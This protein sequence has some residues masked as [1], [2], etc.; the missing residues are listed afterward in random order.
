MSSSADEDKLVPR[1]WRSDSWDA[2]S[3]GTLYK[4][5]RDYLEAHEG[6]CTRSQLLSAIEHDP[7]AMRRLRGAQSFDRLL[8]N[9]KYS[10]FIA[11]E[12][13]RIVRT[14]RRYGQRRA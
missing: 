9:M 4:F 1:K 12:G 11:T 8:Q 14:R 7:D 6:Q 3:A 10:G 2:R 13:E 5:V